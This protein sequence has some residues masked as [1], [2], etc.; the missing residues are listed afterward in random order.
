MA[1]APFHGSYGTLHRRPG[2]LHWA[3]AVQQTSIAGRQASIVDGYYLVLPSISWFAGRIS[4][5][6]GVPTAW[7]ASQTAGCGRQ[8]T[9]VHSFTTPS[10]PS[11]PS[12]P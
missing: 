3:I 8:I 2:S 7:Y 5:F 1:R 6:V 12:V 11:V 10:V 4:E 9:L